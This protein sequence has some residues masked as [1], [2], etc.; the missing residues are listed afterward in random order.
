MGKYL[1]AVYLKSDQKSNWKHNNLQEKNFKIH[2]VK[3]LMLERI[4]IFMFLWAFNIFLD[5]YHVSVKHFI[6]IFKELI[7]ENCIEFPL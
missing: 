3:M 7:G 6:L 1:V 4:L 5:M 2:M